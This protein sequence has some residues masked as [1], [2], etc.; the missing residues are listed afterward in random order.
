MECCDHPGHTEPMNRQHEFTTCSRYCHTSPY[1]G[2]SLTS[3]TCGVVATSAN[4]TRVM[5]TV[6]LVYNVLTVHNRLMMC[7]GPDSPPVHPLCNREVES[8]SRDY[9]IGR[10]LKL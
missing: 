9:K 2:A 5:Q 1:I 6:V 4:T 7:F 8:G 3:S 10:L